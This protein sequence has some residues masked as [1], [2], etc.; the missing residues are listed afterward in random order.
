MPVYLSFIV[1]SL[2]SFFFSEIKR[3][4]KADENSLHPKSYDLWSVLLNYS[5]SVSKLT[6]ITFAPFGLICP[7]DVQNT[8]GQTSNVARKYSIIWFIY[9]QHL[10]PYWTAIFPCVCF[11]IKSITGSL[12]AWILYLV[13]DLCEWCRTLVWDGS[14]VL[15]RFFRLILFALQ[16]Q[17]GHVNDLHHKVVHV[18]FLALVHAAWIE[19]SGG[20][21]VAAAGG[22]RT[23]AF[24]GRQGRLLVS[25][26]PLCLLRH[27]RRE[28]ELFLNG[29]GLPSP[30][31]WPAVL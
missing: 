11:V 3:R 27:K 26:L 29:D 28:L 12:Y 19:G 23:V 14:T 25:H 6:E 1:F 21:K 4:L 10:Q 18:L 13:S 15:V 2:I 7:Q 16:R 30:G 8:R 20:G 9:Y 22:V 17:R 24:F 5:N 31:G